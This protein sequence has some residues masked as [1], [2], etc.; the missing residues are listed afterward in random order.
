MSHRVPE[1]AAGSGPLGPILAL[2]AF[3]LYAGHD[4]VV[5]HLGVTFSVIQIVFFAALFSFPLLAIM[6][7]RDPRPGTL[8]ARNPGWAAVRTLGVV[9]AA[10]LGFFAFT[11]I[12]FAQAYA[13]LFAAPLLV[14]V[15]AIPFLGERV[16]LRRGL[17]VV[18]GLSGV[19]IVLRPGV[20]EVSV[21]HLAGLTAACCSAMVAIASRRIG[22][23]ERAEVLMLW[24]L[25][26]M[27]VVMGAALPW[28]Y[29]PMSLVEM[30][31]AGSVAGLG[32]VAMLLM[33]Q[34]YR[35]A[36][37]ALVA[38]MQYSQILWAVFYGA[39]IFGEWPDLWTLTG[40]GVIIASGLYIVL[41]ES[42]RADQSARP[43]QQAMPRAGA[44]YPAPPS[45]PATHGPS[46]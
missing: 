2:L 9:G 31:L 33:I 24:P 42:R 8:R 40:A 36:E 43:V 12:P 15:L 7:L 44:G 30:S 13:M 14:T 29:V 6:L 22:R 18:V 39:T 21:G 4:V 35:R 16:G 17:A 10:T 27:V 3:A 45:D 25:M 1:P 46:G 26:A 20:V 38:P 19:L 34:A 23:E 41:R 37:A 32:F 11:V 28:V 5:K